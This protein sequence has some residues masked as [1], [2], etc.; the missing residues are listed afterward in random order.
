MQ[1][2]DARELVPTHR[3]RGVCLQPSVDCPWGGGRRGAS[4]VYR[5]AGLAPSL[6]LGLVVR[7]PR[8]QRHTVYH[9]SAAP[10]L[11]S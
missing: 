3:V 10:A 5:A 6:A 11:Q 7:R 2:T 9:C 1:T 8:E 4:T